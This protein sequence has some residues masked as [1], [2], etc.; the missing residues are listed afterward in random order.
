MLSNVLP[1]RMVLVE[2]LHVDVHRGG[3]VLARLAP[4]RPSCFPQGQQ[5]AWL[6]LGPLRVMSPV[7]ILVEKK[8]IL[9]S[10]WL[11]SKEAA[12]LLLGIPEN[13]SLDVAEIY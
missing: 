1:R 10:R 8:Q 9:S 3:F 11:H 7:R 12:Q 2:R 5:V 13:F 6:D 4:S